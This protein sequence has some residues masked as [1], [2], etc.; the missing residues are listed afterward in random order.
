MIDHRKVRQTLRK[1]LFETEG[2]PDRVTHIAYENREFTPPTDGL[3]WLR[4]TY[5]PAA[6][7]LAGSDILECPTNYQIDVYVPL[8]SGTEVCEDLVSKLLEQFRPTTLVEQP[9][10][11]LESLNGVQVSLM[12]ASR[13][14]G[15][16]SPIGDQVWWWVPVDVDLISYARNRGA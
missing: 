3:P 12:R 5:K 13:Q 16:E 11:G 14:Q 9:E 10:G 7:T 8:G 6:E 4:E 2:C 15:R 1:H